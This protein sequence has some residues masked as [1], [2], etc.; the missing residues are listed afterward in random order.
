M[1][2]RNYFLCLIP[3]SSFLLSSC[4]VSKTKDDH[5]NNQS[6]KQNEETNYKE[7]Y[8]LLKSEV[9][10]FIKNNL[11]E[12]QYEKW[13]NNL[14]NI[15]NETG[16]KI[17]TNSNINDIYKQQ[18]EIL[19][20]NFEEIKK[21]YINVDKNKDKINYKEKYNL[22]KSEVENFIKNN[23]TEIQYEKWRDILENNLN[24]ISYK[25]AINVQN[26]GND[27]YE[28]STKALKKLFEEVRKNY[29]SGVNEKPNNSLEISQGIKEQENFTSEWF[30]KIDQ[31]ISI[32]NESFEFMNMVKLEDIEDYYF[33]PNDK[34]QKEAIKKHTYEIVRG[35]HKTI[36]KIRKIYDWIGQNLKY[37]RNDDPTAAIDPV[38]ALNL[39]IAV[40]GGFSN[41]YKA[42]LDS[43]GVKNVVV[44]GWSKF[45]AHQWNL[46]F[47]EES[48]QFFHSDPT[49][50]GD[51]Y[52]KPSIEEFSKD[53]IS[54]QILNK[55]AKVKI[56]NFEYEYNRGFSVYNYPDGQKYDDMINGQIKVV[57]ISQNALRKAKNIYVGEFINRIEYEGGTH[58]IQSF[59]VNVKN[60]KFASKNG[61]LFTKDM[62]NLLV[63]PKKYV[64]A[65]FLLPKSVKT[66]QDW[67]STFDVDNLEKIIVEPGNFWYGSYG[68]I[69]YNNDYTKIIYVPQKIDSV[70]A[71]SSKAILE[72]NDFSWNKNIKEI[73]IPE[74]IKNIPESFINNLPNLKL[75]HLPS[76]LESLDSNAFQNI[77]KDNLKVKLAEKMNENVIRTLEKGNFN[78][79]K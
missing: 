72:A 50:K 40:C 58:N 77:N 60:P 76:S 34:R 49:W 38:H 42:M 2:K 26:Q 32:N 30:T 20:T 1:K 44:I 65:E 28:D 47:D 66:I 74:G 5:N 45:G 21:N 51:R 46:V 63:V 29:K 39:K 4:V 31:N 43:I 64:S 33:H 36:E 23:L 69:L 70:V 11:T 18:F 67:K 10:N 19:K 35:A 71:I 27:F 22:L 79:I 48:K 3:F 14:E 6:T 62:K 16:Y 13:K 61:A 25:I 15:L 8:N 55:D 73:I 59:E 41:L 57:G 37:A 78:M 54:M 52:F 9:E 56:N 7:K 17:E 24:E 68:G 75:I 12:I 53:H